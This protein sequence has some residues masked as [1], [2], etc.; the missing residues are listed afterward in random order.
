MAALG[1]NRLHIMS[2]QRNENQLSVKP[3]SSAMYSKETSSLFAS[4]FMHTTER[5]K[6]LTTREGILRRRTTRSC[7][8]R[9]I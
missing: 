5:M 4:K 3:Q 1:P 2:M 7:H 9:W 6:K 8:S